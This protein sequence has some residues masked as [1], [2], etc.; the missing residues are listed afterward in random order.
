MVFRRNFEIS[1]ITR[2]PKNREISSPNLAS[3]SQLSRN[4]VVK[5]RVRIGGVESFSGFVAEVEVSKYVIFWNLRWNLFPRD[6]PT[7]SLQPN[8]STTQ[9]VPVVN[10]ASLQL[11]SSPFCGPVFVCQAL[12]YGFLIIIAPHPALLWAQM[13]ILLSTRGAG[14]PPVCL[15]LDTKYWRVLL[16]W[17][18]L[19]L[20]V[21]YWNFWQV[22]SDEGRDCSENKADKVCTIRRL[23]T[24]MWRDGFFCADLNS[25]FPQRSADSPWW[26]ALSTVLDR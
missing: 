22:R 14:A 20:A 10:K 18:Q 24:I 5:A 4:I 6:H 1:S 11:A 2:C 23:R 17:A 25:P 13:V 26:S 16:C 19:C 3:F 21:W 8:K 15:R 9:Q 7:G 12:L